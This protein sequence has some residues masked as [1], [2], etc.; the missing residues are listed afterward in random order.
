[1]GT[2]TNAHLQIDSSGNV[3]QVSVN[4]GGDVT[5]FQLRNGAAA[6][7]TSTSLRFVNSTVATATH[8]GAEL[9][10]IR[11]ANDGGS[12]VFKTAAD[13]STTLTERM[14]IDS[15]GAVQIL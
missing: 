15:A 6:T 1:M 5:A 12:L 11:N 14:T 13:T 4:S 8:G 9:T 3:T 10:S 2:G 7:S